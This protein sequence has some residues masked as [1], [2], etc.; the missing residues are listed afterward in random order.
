VVMV[1]D[2]LDRTSAHHA[3]A[4]ATVAT[5]VA[6]SSEWKTHFVSWFDLFVVW[7]FRG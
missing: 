3:S 7:G 1:V 5:V 2:F 6:A 4:A